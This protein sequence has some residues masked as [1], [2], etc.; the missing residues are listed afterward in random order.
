VAP[1]AVAFRDEASIAGLISAISDAAA[2]LG[3]PVRM[4]IVDTVSRA[5]AGGD[6]NSSVDMGKLVAAV[7][8]VKNETKAHVMLVHHSG[9]DAS[10]GARGHSLL[11]GNVDTEIAVEGGDGE[12]T[13]IVRVE[14]QRDL[15]RTRPCS[16]R[17]RQIHLGTNRHGK[18]ITSCVVEPAELPRPKLSEINSTCLQVLHE[19]LPEDV[20]E[21]GESVTNG[22]EIDVWREAVL[23]RLERGG[24]T[25]PNT[26]RVTFKRAKDE[27]LSG[28]HITVSGQC[29]NV[30]W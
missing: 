24:V 27:L 11:K 15:E 1:H 12:R 2:Q 5:L 22:V 13:V 10:K 8:R 19:L 29:V 21:G 18:P 9:K 17:L 7:D 23:S 3:G 4:V 6:E 30:P 26:R 14:K 28:G 25:K 16:F 20:S